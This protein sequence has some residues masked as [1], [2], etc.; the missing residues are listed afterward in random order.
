MLVGNHTIAQFIS[1]SYASTLVQYE[2]KVLKYQN[3]I[4]N[5]DGVHWQM[6][7]KEVVQPSG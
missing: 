7:M 3:Q 2:R 5:Q 4:W 1:I 6:W